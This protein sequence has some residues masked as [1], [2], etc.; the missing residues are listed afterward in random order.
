MPTGTVKWFNP[1]KGFGFI[2]PDDG[3]NDVFVHYSGIEVTENEF[4]TLHE[5]E[6]VEY[7]TR[8]G[9]KGIEAYD[10]KVIGE[11]EPEF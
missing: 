9:K 5:N 3:G 7:E 1:R 4:A 2:I 8:E 11:A 6:K 10:V